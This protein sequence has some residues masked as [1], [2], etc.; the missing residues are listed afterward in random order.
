MSNVVVPFNFTPRGYQLELFQALDGIQGKP[1][2]KKKRAFLRWCRRAGKDKTCLAYIFKAMFERVGVYYYFLP[3][4]AQGRKIIWEGIDRDGFKFLNH[5]P[6]EVIKA[7]NNNEMKIETSNGS[8]FRVI[9][10]DDYDS[11]VGT[12]P[13]GCVFSEYALQD[14]AVWDY[15]RP[16]LAQ[17]GGWAI[18]NGTPRGKNH[19][20]ELDQK[21]EGSPGWF[22]SMVQSLWPDLPNYVQIVTQEQISAERDEGMTEELIEQEF[23]VSYAAGQQ[24]AFYA[25]CIV[26]ARATGRVGNFP[27]ND[28]KW[29][30]TFWDI[31]LSDD[32][33]IWMRQL[34]GSRA[35]WIDYYENN[36]K[37]LAYYVQVL[38]ERGYR[39][40]THYFPHDGGNRSIQS[41]T[42][43]THA[44]VFAEL[45][46]EA[47]IGDEVV[48]VPKAD[49]QL[50]INLTRAR[51]SQ[52]YFNEGTVS[53]GLT[54]LSLYHRRFDS[55]R[56]VFLPH[57]VHDWT[58]HAADALR[59][60]A[61]CSEFLEKEQQTIVQLNT[62][63]NFFD[64]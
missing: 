48:V 40:R 53:D 4:Y 38:K 27:H 23:G 1:E 18:F 57:P 17:N 28:H 63:F 50:G 55:K 6:V 8:I 33:S 15:I 51:F 36:N 11:I 43:T 64:D 3:S 26:A 31:G 61:V 58:S 13:V 37:S 24:G 45:C 2:T 7:I 25:D 10:T 62:D 46:K 30:D 42:L 52:Y 47:G 5:L 34:D 35:V 54:K 12:N 22:K 41:S 32:T 59:T 21:T 39:F 16:I 19:M 44:E 56:R 20:Y 60:E 29:V 49:L 9:G 14:P